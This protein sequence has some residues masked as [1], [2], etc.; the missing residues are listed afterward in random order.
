MFVRDVRWLSCSPS[1]Q[2]SPTRKRSSRKSSRPWWD[3]GLSRAQFSQVLRDEYT[4]VSP[5]AELQRLFSYTWRRIYTWN[6]DDALSNIAHAAQ[7]RKYF[8]GLSDKVSAQEGHEY[9]QIVYLH[10]EAQKPEHGFI[11]SPSEYNAR[12]NR[13]DHDWYRELADRLHI[14]YASHHRQSTKRANLVRGTGPGA[15]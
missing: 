9:L 1:R 7:R 15:A 8:N 11:F 13:N 5:S 14:A 6:I 3:R 12:L 10:G 4:R 2:A